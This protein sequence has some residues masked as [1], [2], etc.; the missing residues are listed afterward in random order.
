MNY[1]KYSLLLICKSISIGSVTN[2]AIYKFI[3]NFD[4][5]NPTD[6]VYHFF[7]F[8]ELNSCKHG[9]K[10]ENILLM[11]INIIGRDHLI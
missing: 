6:V 1:Q 7:V 3:A 9:H 2:N 11:S 10:N 8:R 4:S 5:I